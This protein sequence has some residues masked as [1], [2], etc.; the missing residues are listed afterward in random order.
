MN[1]KLATSRSS[2]PH[3]NHYTT[4]NTQ[5]LGEDK[6]TPPFYHKMWV[7]GVSRFNMSPS[8]VVKSG[9]IGWELAI[10]LILQVGQVPTVGG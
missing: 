1:F 6:G 10:S 4:G 2:V 9:I 5:G 7:T 8:S 3:N